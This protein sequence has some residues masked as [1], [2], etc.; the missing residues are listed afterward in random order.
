MTGQI[1]PA[2][3][4][5]TLCSQC[6]FKMVMSIQN[7]AICEVL[8]IIRFLHAKEETTAEIH[9]QLFSVYGENVMNRQNVAKL[10]HKFEAGRSYV[11]DEN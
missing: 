6:A 10:C 7:P 3:V 11:H 2:T 8:A 1:S 4:T 9:P 5:A